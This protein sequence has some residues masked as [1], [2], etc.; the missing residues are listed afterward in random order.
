MSKVFMY[1]LKVSEIGLTN[2]LVFDITNF[3]ASFPSKCEV[4]SLHAINEHIRGADIDLFIQNS[5]GSYQ[6]YMI[7]AKVMDYRGYYNDIAKW[8]PK[9]Q[10]L[11]LIKGAKKENALPLYLLYN[12]STK[13]SLNGEGKYGT[14]VVAAGEINKFRTNQRKVGYIHGQNKLYFDLIYQYM[15]PYQN[16]FC[17]GLEGIDLPPNKKE[18]EIYTGFPYRKIQKNTDVNP[19]S[20]DGKNDYLE[21][22]SIIKEKGLAPIRIIIKDNFENENVA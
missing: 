2:H 3:Y 21:K 9:S 4:Y 12:G 7:Q 1:N 11:K 17:N 18:N 6:Y 14:S 5:S 10:F 13:N 20:E 16:L 19:L 8:N 22:L 15:E